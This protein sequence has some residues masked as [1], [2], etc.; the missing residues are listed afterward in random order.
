MLAA[1]KWVNTVQFR[2]VLSYNIWPR[3]VTAGQTRDK[4]WR[5]SAFPPL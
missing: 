2:S 3:N 4:A 5:D 1:S